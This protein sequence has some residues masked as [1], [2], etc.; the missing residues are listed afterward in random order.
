MRALRENM[1][2]QFLPYYGEAKR[3]RDVA[4]VPVRRV[5]LDRPEDKALHL[6]NLV[7]VI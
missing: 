7:V 5:S 1:G 2:P 4:T 6:S 3:G